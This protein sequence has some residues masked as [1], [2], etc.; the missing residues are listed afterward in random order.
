MDSGDDVDALLDS[1][2]AVGAATAGRV[3]VD[4]VHATLASGDDVEL[5]VVRPS[6]ATG[7]PGEVVVAD[8][9]VANERARLDA[10]G[11]GW[12]DRRGHLKLR[13]GGTWLDVDVPPVLPARVRQVT[14]PLAGAV[15]SAVA[16]SALLAYPEPMGGVRALAREVGASPGGVSLAVRRLVE[17]GLLTRDR[18][19]AVPGLFWAVVDG[20][21]P[22]WVPLAS[23]PSARSDVVVVGDQAAAA[24]GAPVG[25]SGGTVELLAADPATVR[26]LSRTAGVAPT[27]SAAVARLALA[28]SPVATTASADGSEVDGHPA[29]HPVVV[30]L[31]LAGDTARGAEIVRDWDLRD[32]PW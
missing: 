3:E 4:T 6:H 28:P 24:L 27:P 22:D 8:R 5:R 25:G 10:L 11:A 18:R 16:L 32:R 29:A 9:I 17:A 2:L 13:H 30:A 19:A 7:A 20:W 12:L 15:V 26:R 1:L 14:D 23:M 21:R 31:T